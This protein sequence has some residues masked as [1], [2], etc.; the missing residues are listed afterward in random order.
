MSALLGAAEL[1]RGRGGREAERCG[2]HPLLG[3]GQFAEGVGLRGQP[4][5][6]VRAVDD[7]FT[8]FRVQRA[9]GLPVVP[10]EA[11]VP[12]P[13]DGPGRATAR[14]DVI[15]GLAPPVPDS[16]LIS[17]LHILVGV[18]LMWLSAALWRTGPEVEHSAGP[19]RIPV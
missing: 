12:L 9:A 7:E 19:E 3:D 16:L 15:E 2:E 10:G 1:A 8:S 5:A 18:I 14:V 4:I 11:E 17:A 6:D 13:V